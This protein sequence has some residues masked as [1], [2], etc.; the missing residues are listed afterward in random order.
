MVQ[1]KIKDKLYY[2]RILPK[3]NVYE[4]CDVTV[5]SVNYSG[6]WFVAVDK[7]DKRSYLFNFNDIDNI[8]FTDRNCALSK[9]IEAEE[10]APKVTF[11]TDYE[12]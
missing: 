10:S 6:E 1:L 7:R 8:V 3:V 9:V 12:E 4:V 2:A 5:N 11:H